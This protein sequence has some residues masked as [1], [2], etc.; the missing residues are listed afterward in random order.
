MIDITCQCGH[1]M[2][3]PDGAAG[4][5]GKC[6][7]C[8]QRVEVPVPSPVAADSEFLGLVDEAI[9]EQKKQDSLPDQ[10]PALPSRPRQPA[11][12]S[13]I[14]EVISIELLV[15]GL[16]WIAGLAAIATLLLAAMQLSESNSSTFLAL[17]TLASGLGSALW[18]FVISE[19]IRLLVNIERNT[20]QAKEAAR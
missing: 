7:K 11:P 6:P 14:E 5:H 12:A 15:G 19:I 9:S 4:K 18:T 17:I 3:V 8:G 1:Q 20:R 2:Q 16:R 13:E 10:R